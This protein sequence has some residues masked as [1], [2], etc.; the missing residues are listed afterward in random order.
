MTRPV[1]E[2]AYSGRGGSG[3]IYSPKELEEQGTFQSHS[4]TPKMTAGSRNPPGSS[5]GG[6]GGAGNIRQNVEAGTQGRDVRDVEAKLKEKVTQEVDAGLSAPPPVHLGPP[7][8][9]KE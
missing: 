6:R 4:A 9:D 5:F 8:L 1:Q 2:Y 3:N 7:K